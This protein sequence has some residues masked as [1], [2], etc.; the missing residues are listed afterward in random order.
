MSLRIFVQCKEKSYCICCFQQ[1][2][3][4]EM[5]SD[6]LH[7]YFKINF[8]VLIISFFKTSEKTQAN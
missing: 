8:L 1:K 4:Q 5:F 2:T 3:Q 7:A 6:H